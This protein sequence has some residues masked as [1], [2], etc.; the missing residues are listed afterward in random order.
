MPTNMNIS[1]NYLMIINF[2]RSMTN[3]TYVKFIA[4]DQVYTS[5]VGVAGWAYNDTTQQMYSNTDL[6]FTL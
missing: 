5:I 2:T 1:T 6:M 4:D 3:R